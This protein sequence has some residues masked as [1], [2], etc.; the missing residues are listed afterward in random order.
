M[1]QIVVDR[2]SKHYKV[3][4][5][6]NREKTKPVEVYHSETQQWT[7][8]EHCSDLIVGYEYDWDQDSVDN[9]YPH[10]INLYV[11]NFAERRALKYG[12]N[13]L[14]LKP[15]VKNYALLKDSLFVLHKDSVKLKSRPGVVIPL[16]CITEYHM[17]RGGIW[18]S[19]KIHR[20]GP[21]EDPPR[22]K[23]CM[24]LYACKPG[25]LMVVYHSFESLPYRQEL[26]WLYDLASE[27]WRDLPKLPGVKCVFVTKQ[28]DPCVSFIGI[29]NHNLDLMFGNP[30]LVHI[31]CSSQ[32]LYITCFTI[33]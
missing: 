23:H 21:F 29:F 33:L 4:V 1:V 25:F 6:R 9:Y 17:R 28:V 5:V 3:V 26:G 12:D 19:V 11:Y 31:L 24:R 32:F 30:C 2:Q 20:C 27:K 16:Y 14:W 8:G 15:N 13:S 22:G 7:K 10:R 18:Q